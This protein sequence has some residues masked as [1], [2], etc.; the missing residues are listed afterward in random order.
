MSPEF[1]EDPEG[2][3]VELADER[4]Q[5]IIEAHNELAEH[6]EDLLRRSLHITSDGLLMTSL[7]DA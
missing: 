5:H 7:D 2:R 6:R 1:V 4:W 3:R